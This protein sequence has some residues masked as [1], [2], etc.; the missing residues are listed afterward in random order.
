MNASVIAGVVLAGFAVAYWFGADAIPKSTLS[1]NVGADGLPKLLAVTLGILSVIM[2]LQAWAKL[3]RPSALTTTAEDPGRPG[4]S[5]AAGF[6]RQAVAAGILAI[7]LGYL[8]ILPYAGY[9]VS[10][11]L[12]LVAMAWYHGSRSWRGVLPFAVVGAVVF[13]LIFVVLLDVSMPAGIW[14]AIAGG[15]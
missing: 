14:P 3:R 13:Y 7:G 12:L 4:E 15:S 2:I 6:R 9:L 8:A 5:L 1:G 10:V 11:A